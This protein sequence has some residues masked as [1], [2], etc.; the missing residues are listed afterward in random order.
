MSNGLQSGG[1][2]A[3]DFLLRKI[4]RRADKQPL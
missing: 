3:E 2:I 4:S 1:F